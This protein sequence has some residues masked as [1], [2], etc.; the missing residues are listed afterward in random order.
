MATFYAS[1]AQNVTLK[2]YVLG[3]I[4]RW[5]LHKMQER[6]CYTFEYLWPLFLLMSVPSPFYEVE[7]SSKMCQTLCLFVQ[8]T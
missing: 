7:R 8:Q 1:T 5:S 6:Y 2:G 3:H 4:P